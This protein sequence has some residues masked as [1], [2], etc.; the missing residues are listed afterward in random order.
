MGVL[1]MG[2]RGWETSRVDT[3]LTMATQQHSKPLRISDSENKVSHKSIVS[4]IVNSLSEQRRRSS[5][6]YNSSTAACE[7]LYRASMVVNHRKA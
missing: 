3:H 2:Y 1:R 6:S 5:V 7:V 4:G